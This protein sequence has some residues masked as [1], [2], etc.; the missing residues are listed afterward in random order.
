MTDYPDYTTEDA[1]RELLPPDDTPAIDT[2]RITKQAEVIRK[3]HEEFVPQ[4]D[5]DGEPE[6]ED[7]EQDVGR[8]GEDVTDR[9]ER[10]EQ[11]NAQATQA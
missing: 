9:W 4:P 3:A 8:D 5:P 1:T 7:G 10:P 2:K 11:G 6:S